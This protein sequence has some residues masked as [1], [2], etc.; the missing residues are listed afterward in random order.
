MPTQFGMRIWRDL[1]W[2]YSANELA[3]L[4]GGRVRSTTQGRRKMFLLRRFVSM[5]TIFC[6]ALLFTNPALYAQLSTRGTI[7]GTVTD[8]TGAVVQGAAVKITDEAT[9]VQ[10]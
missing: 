2:C 10:T 6:V 1:C 3:A 7:T 5:V 8:P 9:K 4:R